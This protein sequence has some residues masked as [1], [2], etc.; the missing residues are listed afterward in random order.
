MWWP[1]RSSKQE[2]ATGAPPVCHQCDPGVP[3]VDHQ[4]D[5]SAPPVS[6][7]HDYRD[8]IYVPP[9]EH[10]V[11]LL[12]ELRRL[13]EHWRI[14]E[15]A[16]LATFHS[17]LCE[18]LGWIAHSWTAV[19]REFARL[20]GVHKSKPRLN[21]RRLTLYEIAPAAE[22]VVDLAEARKRAKK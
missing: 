3:P 5:T 14:M 7:W 19:G 1:F 20:P 11:M 15:Q 12:E 6:D 10:A 13:G 8:P 22:A 21:G 18:E 2:V 16:E 17:E 9:R 4:C